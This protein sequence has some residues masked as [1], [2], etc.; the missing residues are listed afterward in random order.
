MLS[1]LHIILLG[2]FGIKCSGHG[3]ISDTPSVLAQSKLVTSLI[4]DLGYEQYQGYHNSSFNLNTWLGIRYAAPPVASLRWRA[5]QKPARNRDKVINAAAFPPRCP[6]GPQAPLVPNY[7]YTGSEDCLFLSVY[8]PANASGPLPVFVW[9]HG[10]GYGGGQGNQDIGNLSAINHDSFVSVVIQYRLGAFGF[11]ASDEVYNDGNVNAGLLDQH[12]T[13]QWVQEHIYL[14]NGDPRRVTIAGESAGAG[15]VMLQAMAYNGTLGTSLFNNIIAASPYLPLQYPFYGWQPSQAYY[16][17]ARAV[18]CDS[19]RAY[20]NS[21]ATIIACL[22]AAPSHKLQQANAEVGAS[23]T[24]GTWAFLPTTDFQFIHHRPSEQLARRAVNGLR[25][26]SGNNA[27]EGAAFV[28]PNITTDAEFEAWLRLE[29]PLLSTAD[30]NDIHTMYYAPG[31]NATIPFAT[32]G[33]CNGATAINVGSE[34]VGPG[35]RAIN[36]YSETTFVCPSYWLAE[37]FDPKYGKQAFKYQYSVP[38]AQHGADL[39]AEGLRAA[40]INV[41]PDFYQAFTTVWGN[42]I[43]D[44][45]PS[46]ASS[47]ANGN[48]NASYNAAS[49][50]PLFYTQGQGAYQMLNLNETGGIEYS[51]HVVAY[52]EP[53]VEQYKGPGLRNS[54]R[55]VDAYTWEGGR[56]ARCEFWKRIGRRVPE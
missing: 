25:V 30:L 29:Y 11:L 55:Q 31:I 54:I 14:F 47:L 16:T 7:N 26:L 56:G 42:F 44:D 22:R 51:A 40:T 48:S 50:W 27:M 24:W 35:Q 6:Q 23:G 13:L 28:I 12:A 53:N 43:T 49:R 21:S 15:S 2:F 19:G 3:S 8:S 5:P 20:G 36:L 38:A 52:P 34:A 32:C 4:V 41:S 9:I 39:S 45:N 18:G 37:A 17:F 1:Y 33:D 10:G 46:I